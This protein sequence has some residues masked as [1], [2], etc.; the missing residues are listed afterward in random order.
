M[1]LHNIHV[2]PKLV[3][4]IITNH[5]LS[6]APDPDCIPLAVLKKYGPEL[7][8][9]LVELFN[10]HLTVVSGRIARAFNKSGAT[11]TAALDI[12]KAFDRVWH[13]GLLYKLKSYKISDQLFGLIWSFL[14]SRWLEMVLNHKS[15]QEYPIN[16]GVPLSIHGPL[17]LH[18]T[19]FQY[20]SDLPDNVFCNIA[21]LCQWYYSLLKVWPGIWFVATTRI[22]F[23]TWI[24]PTK[25]CRLRQGFDFNTG[26]AQ[27][28]LLT[29]LITLI[30]LMWK[31]MDLLLRKS[32]LLRCW[33]CLSLLGLLYCLHC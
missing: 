8:Y 6:K 11:R 1:K 26:K 2:T 27:L 31:W 29:G 15:S 12:S 19:L 4:K 7:S 28:V 30:L 23:R 9:I 14:R 5:D 24:W 18:F 16:A 17:L 20:I 25:H 21:V 32:H 22:G 13:A 3:K 33:G 10:M